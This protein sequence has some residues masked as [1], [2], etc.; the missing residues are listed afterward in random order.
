MRANE[1]VYRELFPI[2]LRATPNPHTVFMLDL[3]DSAGGASMTAEFH[4]KFIGTRSGTVLFRNLP[5]FVIR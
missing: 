2:V 3:T 5:D 4:G 1:E